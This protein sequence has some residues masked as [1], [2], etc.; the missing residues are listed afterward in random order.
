MEDKKAVALIVEDHP[1]LATFFAEVL[2]D[3]AYET[4]VMPN[5]QAAME[6]LEISVPDLVLLDLHL[7]YISG[8]QILSYIRSEQRLKGT[9]VFVVSA[10]GTRTNFLDE[11][12]DLVLN[13]P[14]AYKQL[15]MFAS[16]VYPD[17]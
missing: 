8:E 17:K 7:P 11:E 5:G 1:M 3:A 10:D 2:Q 12:A 4:E 6:R 13:K 16:R 15:Y 14:V 9:R